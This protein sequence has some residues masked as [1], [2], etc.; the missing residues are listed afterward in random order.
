MSTEGTICTVCHTGFGFRQ[1]SMLTILRGD[2]VSMLT[3]TYPHKPLRK[4]NWPTA[5]ARLTAHITCGLK[6]DL[7]ICKHSKEYAH[8]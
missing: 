1:D 5:I 4:I 8:T 3:H 6:S 7:A 2:K